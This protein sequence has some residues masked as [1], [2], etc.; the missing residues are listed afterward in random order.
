VIRNLRIF[1]DSLAGFQRNCEISVTYAK[2]ADFRR[3]S[4]VNILYF[5]IVTVLKLETPAA[6]FLNSSRSAGDSPAEP[7]IE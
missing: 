6:M 2:L 7:P 5:R 4:G 1:H 3:S